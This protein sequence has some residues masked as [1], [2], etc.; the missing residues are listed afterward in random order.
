MPAAPD[1]GLT[2]ARTVWFGWGWPVIVDDGAEEPLEARTA[3][4]LGRGP[5]KAG[6]FSPDNYPH[7]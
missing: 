3:P 4:G 7:G 2:V 5:R 1:A 6:E